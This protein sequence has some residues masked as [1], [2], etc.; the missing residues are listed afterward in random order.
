VAENYDALETRDPEDRER[1]LLARLP[2]QIEHARKDAAG[3]ARILKDV[4]PR[5]I[6]SRAALAALPV[7]RKSDLKALQANF[8]LQQELGFLKADMDA[9]KHAD[10]SIAREAAKRL[11]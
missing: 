1:D 9:N 10:L 7:T 5:E 2:R 6:V 3:F 8:K 11:K 4:D